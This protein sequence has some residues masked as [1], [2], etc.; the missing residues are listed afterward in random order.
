MS[1]ARHKRAIY[2]MSLIL[3]ALAVFSPPLLAQAK[4]AAA[5]T[6]APAPAPAAAS[7]S[8]GAF[9][10]QMLAFGALDYIASDIATQ[11]CNAPDITNTPTILIFDQAS[12]ANVQAYAAFLANA[13]LLVGAY[14]NIYIPAV[15]GKPQTTAKGVFDELEKLHPDIFTNK[16]HT[17]DPKLLTRGQ[18]VLQRLQDFSI[19]ITGDPLSDTS[20]LLQ[21]IASSSNA[22]AANSATIPDSALAVLITQ[23]LAANST[24]A[25]GKTVVYPPIYGVGSVTDYAR[26]DI[27]TYLSWLNANRQAVYKNLDNIW[28]ASE[29]QTNITAQHSAII[30]QLTDINAL[31]D[32][33]MNSLFQVNASSGV[34]GSASVI[35]G[36]QL[37]M[38]MSGHK[39]E[40]D[41]DPIP[42]TPP[43]YVLLATIISAGG[44]Q[45]DHK[46]FWT[47]LGSGDQI[48][49]SGGAIVNVAMWKADSAIPVYSAELRYRTPFLKIKDPSAFTGVDAG[50]NLPQA[51]NPV[52]KPTPTPN[53][54]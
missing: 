28:G 50:S 48:T 52:P 47:A 30:G 34:I 41:T 15:A 24:C 42:E 1:L 12:L 2:T 51:L 54:K 14:R 31:Y 35:Q 46:T 29:S 21:A 17:V 25:A 53:P 5:A 32:N 6:P 23:K 40:S 39:K 16:T 49:Y 18:H 19:T 4:K 20:S 38:L 26:V 43:A 13:N 7:S 45:K 9:E 37:A 3:A 8:N 22:E 44:T 36:H 11:V 33:F 10:S 27:E